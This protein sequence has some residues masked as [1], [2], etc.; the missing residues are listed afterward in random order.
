ML[1]LVFMICG[2]MSAQNT[3]HKR[4]IQVLS[5][6]KLTITGD[7]NI[8]DFTC[9]FDNSFLREPRLILAEEVEDELRFKNA[10]LSLDI[11]GFDCGSRGINNDF[12]ELL[13]SREYPEILLKLERVQLMPGQRAVASVEI[14]IAG[15][16]RA[17]QIPVEIKNT[18]NPGFRGSLG[19][20]IR[21]FQL[22]APRKLFGMIVVEDEIQI[23]FD[24]KIQML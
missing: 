2:G 14:S 7:T 1:L 3:F 24:L 22:E 19:L 8:K 12:Q 15:I 17:Y 10:M 13:R 9:R 18:S 6:S 16:T 11:D 21:D 20:N 5:A 23:N 4:T